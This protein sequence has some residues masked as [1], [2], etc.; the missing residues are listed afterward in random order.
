MDVFAEDL[1]CSDDERVDR[2][3]RGVVY[4]MC[5]IYLAEL[6]GALK[7]P[8]RVHH[9]SA[10]SS[11]CLGSCEHARSL[12]GTAAQTCALQCPNSSCAQ[13]Y[14][15]EIPEDTVTTLLEPFLDILSQGSD[16]TT[17][18]RVGSRVFEALLDGLEGLLSGEAIPSDLSVFFRLDMN[19]L[20][21]LLMARASAKDTR[22]ENRAQLYALH[23]RVG[24]SY[25]CA[26][27]VQLPGRCC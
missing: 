3:P 8:A 15:P 5:D 22:E 19:R 17:T 11:G 24:T 13:G 20:I 27:R 10:P 16:V 12:C 21:E 14:R 7:V 18:A 2:Y 26:H 4:H 6:D 1:F 25:A 9:L 23:R